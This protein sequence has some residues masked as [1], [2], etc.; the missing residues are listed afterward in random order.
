MIINIQEHQRKPAYTPRFT[1]TMT[2]P[3]IDRWCR[4]QGLEEQQLDK[5]FEFYMQIVGVARVQ[6]L[7]LAALAIACINALE[8]TCEKIQQQG[9]PKAK[10][11]PFGPG[12]VKFS[13]TTAEESNGGIETSCCT[14]P[15][16]IRSRR[17]SPESPAT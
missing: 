8:S 7:P 15:R 3:E 16:K 12:P 6:N 1:D 13:N 17:P 10:V 9:K 5:A 2:L 14:Q 11:I 4:Q